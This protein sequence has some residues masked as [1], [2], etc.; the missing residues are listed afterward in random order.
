VPAEPDV[1]ESAG[2]DAARATGE[3]LPLEPACDVCGRE[4]VVVARTRQRHADVQR[5]LA[6]GLTLSGISR[7]LGLDRT[8]VRRFAR[9]ADVEELLVKA[10]H[11]E[12]LLDGHIQYLQARLAAGVDNATL[13]YTEIRALGYTG[14]VQT[15]R[16]FVHPQ[17]DGHQAG[18]P[19]LHQRPGSGAASPEVPKPP[20]ISRWIMTDPDR[21]DPDDAIRLDQILNACPELQATAIHVRAFADIMNKRRGDRIH[22]WLHAITDDN[23]PALRSLAT[24]LRRDLDAVIAGLSTHWNSG[25]AEGNVNRIKTIK[26]QMYG[27]ASFELLRHRILLTT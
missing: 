13:L 22:D 15:V 12:S 5:L 6:E 16:R 2:D 11:R 25:P 1:V 7:R 8:T 26:R 20:Q 24:G 21:L 14:S 17:R 19:R 9:T 27:R 23:L 18:H 3:L 10:T 4:R